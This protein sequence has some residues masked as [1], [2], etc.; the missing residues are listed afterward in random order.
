MKPYVKMQKHLPW[1]TFSSQ[2][3][4]GIR[5]KDHCYRHDTRNE[6]MCSLPFILKCIHL[7][8]FTKCI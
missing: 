6:G 5:H 2:K 3:V 1:R 7:P 8:H 4:A